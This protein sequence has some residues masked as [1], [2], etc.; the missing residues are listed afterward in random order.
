LPDPSKVNSYLSLYR[1]VLKSAAESGHHRFVDEFF[2]LSDPGRMEAAY[3]LTE[4]GIHLTKNGYHHTAAWLEHGLSLP[5]AKSK[6]PP[7]QWE[8]LRQT[9]IAKNQQYFYRWRPQ[10]ETYL[11]GFRKHEQGKNSAE[12]PLFD[13]VVEKLEKEIARLR[14]PTN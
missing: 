12:I 13:P 8:K 4:D 2:T 6:L 14:K 3:P 10:N 7:A 5:E 11:F 1:D 9:I